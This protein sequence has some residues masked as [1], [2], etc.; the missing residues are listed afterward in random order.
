MQPGRYQ[1]GNEE[2]SHL[3]VLIGNELQQL[4]SKKRLLVISNTTVAITLERM[5]ENFITVRNV[6]RRFISNDDA[7][8]SEFLRIA[9]PLS[10]TP[11]C[12]GIEMDART[13]TWKDECAKKAAE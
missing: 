13:H 12:N 7:S 5:E 3:I 1:E 8:E 10:G 4:C 11:C 2:A 9:S 6:Q